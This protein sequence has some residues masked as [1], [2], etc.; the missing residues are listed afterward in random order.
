MKYLKNSLKP[1]KLEKIKKM[2]INMLPKKLKKKMKVQKQK[3]KK[4]R[5]K[6]R[7]ALETWFPNSVADMSLNNPIFSTNSKKLKKFVCLPKRKNV[8]RNLTK[9]LRILIK[10]SNVF[11][12]NVT[13]K[14][15]ICCF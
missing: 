13:N 14:N 15:R 6:K 1:I 2:R 11:Q 8:S 7:S 9:K 10:K 12:I 5:K 4:R 3:S